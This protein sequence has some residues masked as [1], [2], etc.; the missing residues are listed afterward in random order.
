MT[1]IPDR[2]TRRVMGKG[3]TFPDNDR[4]T[5]QWLVTPSEASLWVFPNNNDATFQDQTLPKPSDLL[6]HYN[7]GAAAVKQWGK[8]VSV[9]TERPGVPRPLELVPAPMGP[10]KVANEHLR[11]IKKRNA[12]T[13]KE[14]QGSRKK[15]KTLSG[16]R[17]TDSDS[18]QHS[19]DEDDVV[20]F[21][22]GNSKVAQ[23]R[24]VR[25]EQERGRHVEKWRD[26]VTGG[27][28]S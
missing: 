20:L 6:L 19:W 4:Y 15:R 10:G 12:V 8:N 23:E 1:D 9:L 25:E 27:P 14:G 21:F 3:L 24:R 2:Y 22:W 17:D 26:A 16:A 18:V 11:S 28:S 5:L 13:S 7:Y